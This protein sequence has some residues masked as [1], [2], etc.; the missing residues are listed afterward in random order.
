MLFDLQTLFD[1]A[2]NNAIFVLHDTSLG[3]GATEIAKEIGAFA[4]SGPRGIS[5]CTKE[6]ILKLIGG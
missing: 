5:L 3:N 1:A 6:N 2:S 4:I